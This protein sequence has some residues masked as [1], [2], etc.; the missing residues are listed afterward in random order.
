MYVVHSHSLDATLIVVQ[1]GLCPDRTH[2]VLELHE[3][4]F[5][6]VSRLLLPFLV[7]TI[8]FLGLYWIRWTHLNRTAKPDQRLT[9]MHSFPLHVLLLGFVSYYK[10][11][12][13]PFYDT[14]SHNVNCNIFG[15]AVVQPRGYAQNSCLLYMI[16]HLRE[17]ITRELSTN[18]NRRR[19]RTAKLGSPSVSKFVPLTWFLV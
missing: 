13:I 3:T 2:R 18:G 8:S 7:L 15:S 9:Y 16:R 4:I 5:P 19:S 10:Q 1:H 17:R 14:Y 12:M 6:Q 11:F